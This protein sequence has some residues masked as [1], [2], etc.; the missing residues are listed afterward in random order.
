MSEETL[1][2]EDPASKLESS[3]NHVKKAADDL[4]AAASSKAQEFRGA[5]EAKAAEYRGKAEQAYSDAR[6]R[7]RTYQDDGEQYI[8]ENPTKACTLGAWHRLRARNHL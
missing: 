7:A 3:K 1:G 2:N 6:T 5:A 4:K 8:R